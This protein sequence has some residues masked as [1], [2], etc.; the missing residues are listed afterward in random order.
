MAL[1]AVLVTAVG[2]RVRRAGRAGARPTDVSIDR[3]V[4]PTSTRSDTRG[5][6]AFGTPAQAPLCARCRHLRR[7]KCPVMN[8]PRTGDDE[9]DD[10]TPSTVDDPHDYDTTRRWRRRDTTRQPTTTARR[11]RARQRPKTTTRPTTR[12][13]S[14][15]CNS[16]TRFV[17]AS[18]RE[19]TR[20]WEQ[21]DRSQAL[22]RA[23]ARRAQSFSLLVREMPTGM[24]SCLRREPGAP[25][26]RDR[27]TALGKRLQRHATE[28]SAEGKQQMVGVTVNYN[29]TMKGFEDDT[30]EIRWSLYSAK[31]SVPVPQELADHPHR[32][33]IA[34]TG[35]RGLRGSSV[36][37]NPKTKGRHFIR[38]SVHDET[39]ILLDLRRHAALWVA[40][41]RRLFRG[42]H[43]T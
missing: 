39:D 35:A 3:D 29:V 19:S 14:A 43:R 36:A 21:G 8:Q 17:S 24:A 22:P 25:V 42:G 11:P 28:L 7:P 18:T 37:P 4:I 34:R 33:D 16:A 38:V 10:D 30:V 12:A 5:G 32:S 1:V 40:T 2:A 13:P 27:G 9:T 23:V 20:R 41:T 26:G 15:G 6:S 31:S